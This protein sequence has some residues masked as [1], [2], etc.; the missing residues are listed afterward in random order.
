MLMGMMVGFYVPLNKYARNNDC[1]SM[2]WD[3]ASNTLLLHKMFDG[4]P[5]VNVA[6]W[7]GLVADGVS[8]YE[9][10]TTCMD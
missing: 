4:G 3:V 5:D 9:T 7:L 6:F 1:Y 8:I 10:A 2:F